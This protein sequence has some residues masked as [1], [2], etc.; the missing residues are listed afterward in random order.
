M[1]CD[2]M[3]LTHADSWSIAEG[4]KDAL[5]NEFMMGTIVKAFWL[6]SFRIRKVFGIVMELI[7][8]Y[9]Y[10]YALFDLKA[11]MP[12]KLN[13]CGLRADLCVLRNQATQT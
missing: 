10:G 9:H 7:V 1:V 6:K 3:R 5:A 8:G 12:A 11:P 2:G 4:Q 13:A